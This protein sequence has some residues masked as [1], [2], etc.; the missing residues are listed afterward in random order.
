MGGDRAPDEIVRGA[1]EASLARR[2]TE[3]IL[4]GDAP[5]IGALLAETRHDAERLRVEHA[6]QVV[7]MDEKPAEALAAKPE[8]SIAVA[9]RLVAQGE[10]DALVSAGNT[11]ASVLACAR[12]F[13]LIPGVRR[14]GLAAVYPTEMR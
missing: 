4:V 2:E 11:G 12:S 5:R 1:A 13:K 10:A 7:A 9:A 3:I 6:A 14:A 8:S